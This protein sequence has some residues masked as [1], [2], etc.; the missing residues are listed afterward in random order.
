MSGKQMY[1]WLDEWMDGFLYSELYGHHEVGDSVLR[2][3]WSHHPGSESCL[4][5]LMA[6]RS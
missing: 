1:K 5:S 6:E 2:L 3:P 4:H